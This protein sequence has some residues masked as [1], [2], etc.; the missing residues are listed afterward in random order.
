[1]KKLIPLFS[2]FIVFLFPIHGKCAEFAL[3]AESLE[4]ISTGLESMEYSSYAQFGFIPLSG[5]AK[6]SPYQTFG[7]TNIN[8]MLTNAGI[9]DVYTFDT[10]DYDTWNDTQTWEE[11]ITI[12]GKTVVDRG[13]VRIVDFNNGFYQGRAFCSSDGKLLKRADVADA[14]TLCNIQFGGNALSQADWGFLGVDVSQAIQ[15]SNYSYNYQTHSTAGNMYY[16]N[17]TARPG[18][19]GLPGSV[20]SCY[21]AN[22]Y[23]P[24]L[25]VP[26][27]G[28]SGTSI[29][30]WYTNNPNLIELKDITNV[31][32]LNND[33]ILSVTPGTYT[34]NGYTYNYQVT[35]SSRGGIASHAYNGTLLD[36]FDNSINDYSSYQFGNYSSCVYQYLDGT[37]VD[38]FC[39]TNNVGK[40][41]MTAVYGLDDVIDTTADNVIGKGV[42]PNYG[43][44]NPSLSNDGV[45]PL[46]WDWTFV[47]DP[48]LPI[49][50]KRVVVIEDD[51]A[52]E[53]PI[54]IIVP[55][56]LPDLPIVSG[57]QSRFPFSIPWDI[58][59]ML[60][61]L[62]GRSVAPNFHISWYIQPINYTWTFDLD[63]SAFDAQASIFRNC[64]LI[65]FIIGLALFSFR[66]FFGQ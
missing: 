14:Q 10:L 64:I 20:W 15:D 61:G 48:D 18:D 17:V 31:T 42:S 46:T 56:E 8:N 27:N 24:G 44:Y 16:Y 38:A 33:G 59:N 51:P 30:S 6:Q 47:W 50:N 52:I 1:M 34:K 4:Y 36:Y 62:R 25:I 2:L 43:E 65:S 60:Y 23:I 22:Q 26:T 7:N 57:L 35:L 55:S 28:S 32:H 58:K 54:P 21:I 5:E 13:D 29:S 39:P 9:T 37:Y 40:M 49:P 63:L 3:S 66:H 12:D 45:F 53:E 41:D 11:F 19:G